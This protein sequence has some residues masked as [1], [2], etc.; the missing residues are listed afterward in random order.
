MGVPEKTKSFNKSEKDVEVS[1]LGILMDAA[2]SKKSFM[3]FIFNPK[4]F[5]FFGCTL[6]ALYGTYEIVL[7][8]VLKIGDFSY[9]VELCAFAVSG[10]WVAAFMSLFQVSIQESINRFRALNQQL[11]KEVAKLGKQVDTLQDTADKLQDELENFG[12]IRE[13]MELYA[14]ESGMEM[15]ELLKESGEMFEKMNRAAK[16]NDM[17]LLQKL[18]A[19]VEFRDGDEGMTFKEFKAFC[20]RVPK[21]Y[22]EKCRQDQEKK[23]AQ[24][25]G[26]DGIIQHEELVEF[27]KELVAECCE[28]ASA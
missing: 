15:G 25:A 22:R 11:A 28:P 20:A 3:L 5:F 6:I 18:A 12:E 21:H 2:R 10:M 16:K 14:L 23:Y 26:E 19:D 7:D 4:H 9:S 24:I 17:A 8:E 27:F 13:A 1:P